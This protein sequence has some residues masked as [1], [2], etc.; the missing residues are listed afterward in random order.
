MPIIDEYYLKV[1]PLLSCRLF[2]S[3]DG[4]RYEWRRLSKDAYDVH[5]FYILGLTHDPTDVMQLYLIPQTIIAKFRLEYEDTPGQ[6]CGSR[7]LNF[8]YG[9]ITS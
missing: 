5:A 3:E 8:I 1:Y 6:L 4:T 2:A 7:V 9:H